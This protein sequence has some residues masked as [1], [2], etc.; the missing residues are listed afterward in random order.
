MKKDTIDL[1]DFLM[2][3]GDELRNALYNTRNYILGLIAMLPEDTELLSS[4]L[5]NALFPL[6][7]LIDNTDF[8]DKNKQ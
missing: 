7:Y 1:T 5:S 8:I 6:T 4:E 2:Y 3:S